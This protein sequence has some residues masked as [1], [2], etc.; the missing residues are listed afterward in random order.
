MHKNSDGLLQLTD[1]F[2]GGAA[3]VDEPLSSA[4]LGGETTADEG[5]QD[6]VTSVGH[7]WGVACQLVF[8]QGWKG[9]QGS[10]QSV[11]IQ[12]RTIWCNLVDQ[13][14]MSVAHVCKQ[15]I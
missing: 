2:A 7:D 12:L 1:D 8:L 4:E 11:I 15:F 13:Q 3:G 9:Q 10:K 14:I 6:A 5:V